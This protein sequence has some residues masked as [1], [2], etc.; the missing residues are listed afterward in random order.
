MR[1]FFIQREDGT[2]LALVRHH[3]EKWNGDIDGEPNSNWTHV[4][5]Y[6]AYQDLLAKYNLAITALEGCVDDRH[7]GGVYPRHTEILKILSGET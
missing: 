3:G 6:Q 4:I 1:D 5:E 7:Y 2:N